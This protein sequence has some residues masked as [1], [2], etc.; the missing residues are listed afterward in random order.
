MFRP[1]KKQRF[2]DQIA[3]LIQQKII[4]DNLEIGTNLP[5]EIEMAREFEVS[6]S[7]VREALRI[8]ELSGLVDIR[9]GPTGGI[10]VSNVYHEPVKR[11][12]SNLIACG[13]V[14]IQHLFEARLLIEPQIA[15]QAA[16]Q[17]EKE[18]LKNFKDLLEDSANHFDNA[19][20]LK[21]NNL[22]FHLLL[23]K[24][25]GNPVLAIM[26]ESVFELLVEQTLDFVDL[27]LERHFYKVHKKIFQVIEDKKPTEAEKLVK[28]DILDVRKKIKEYEQV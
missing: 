23:A 17:A 27:P 26:L 10:F 9:K 19:A 20:H 2:S 7:V 13:D 1:L 15:R 24:A 22:K 8:L 14:T 16:R 6:R 3:A 12:I 18:D 21:Q 4:E 11:S 5:S 28:A 25:S